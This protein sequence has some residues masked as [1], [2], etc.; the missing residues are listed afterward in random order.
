MGVNRRT[1]LLSA[2][3]GVVLSLIGDVTQLSRPVEPAHSTDTLQYPALASH[4]GGPIVNPEATMKAFRDIR[5]NHPNMLIEMDVHQLK[6]GAL[7]IWHDVDVDGVLVKNMTTAQW[8]KVT[9]PD[10]A[11]GTEPAPFLNEVLAEFGNTDVTLVIELKAEPALQDFIAALWPY[12]SN[13]ITQTFNATLTSVLVR[14]GFKAMQLSSSW[15]PPIVPGAYA[16][17]VKETLMTQ[18]TISRARDAGQHVW[19][20]T[21]DEQA[22][23]DDLF[24]MGVDGVMS[25]DPRLVIPS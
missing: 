21:V 1:V 25:N 6:D 23:M 12:R 10:P 13:I 5:D 7:V 17:G 11:G 18:E 15:Q 14:S 2:V 9:V 3:G 22:R 20:W 8:R 4:R 24:N 16:I 19:A